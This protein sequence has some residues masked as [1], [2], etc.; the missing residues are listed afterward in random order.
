MVRFGGSV[1]ASFT[2]CWV[3]F[4]VVSMRFRF[5]LAFS[6]APSTGLVKSSSLN[7]MS[8]PDEVADMVIV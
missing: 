5:F 4:I 7:V 6:R 2:I 3:N 1:R 8:S